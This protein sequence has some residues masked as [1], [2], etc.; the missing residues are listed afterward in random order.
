MNALLSSLPLLATG[1]ETGTVSSK[2]RFVS[3]GDAVRN[4]TE[5]TGWQPYRTIEQKRGKIGS[6]RH[7]VLFRH[8][9]YP[10]NE[11]GIPQIA[12]LNS[13]NGSSSFRLMLSMHV[14]ACSNG[15][16]L[17]TGTLTD[18]RI[19]HIGNSVLSNVEAAINGLTAQLPE[20]LN[21]IRRMQ[22]TPVS[23]NEALAFA[24]FG[25]QLRGIK[26]AQPATFFAGRVAESQTA[27]TVWNI[28]NR[29]QE[30]LIR[31]GFV[32]SVVN[33]DTGNVRR[34]TARKIGGITAT[35]KVNTALWAE[36]LKL[37]A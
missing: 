37:A 18:Y 24:E 23:P 28:F 30:K 19:R 4:I 1:P 5:K 9:N 15:L 36:A 6:G 34:L 16:F 2:Y 10:G 21:L 12:L 17:A 33:Q 3:S 7:I 31:G 20:T 22:S 8:P 35:V 25:A 14:L 32:Y 26:T 29:V 11:T 13:H 27:P